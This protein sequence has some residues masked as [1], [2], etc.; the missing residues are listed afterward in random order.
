MQS[1]HTHIQYGREVSSFRTDAVARWTGEISA[2]IAVDFLRGTVPAVP[3]KII[4]LKIF[5]DWKSIFGISDQFTND[6]TW[7]SITFFL[8]C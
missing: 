7:S 2:G 6:L 1:F 8:P 3:Y 5:S 4:N